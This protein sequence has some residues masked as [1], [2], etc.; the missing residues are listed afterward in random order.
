[1]S[2]FGGNYQLRRGVKE[3]GLKK[4]IKGIKVVVKDGVLEN[5]LINCLCFQ[6]SIFYC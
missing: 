3:T 2:D 4:G 1:M 5:T 6:L